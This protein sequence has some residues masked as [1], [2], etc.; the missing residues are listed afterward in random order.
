M[1]LR[2]IYERIQMNW[3][4]NFKGNRAERHACASSNI[5]RMAY[6]FTDW[7]PEGAQAMQLRS[8]HLHPSDNECPRSETQDIQKNMSCCE[9]MCS[10]WSQLHHVRFLYLLV[11]GLILFLTKKKKKWRLDPFILKN[12]CFMAIL[13]LFSIKTAEELCLTHIINQTIINLDILIDWLFTVI[14]PA[15]EFF[16]YMETSLLPVKGCK[17]LAYARRSGS[18]SR[19]GSSSC[20]TSCDTGHQF[21]SSL[22]EGPPHL[23]WH[24]RGCRGSILTR[25]LTRQNDNH[26]GCPKTYVTLLNGDRILIH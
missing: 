13:H 4:V 5:C 26:T 11:K 15:Q 9:K 19:E 12:Q 6:A 16:T 3:I 18:L 23:V 10:L 20:H 14:R 25:I 17:I 2:T 21:F 24:T 22:I 1:L 8:S 7:T